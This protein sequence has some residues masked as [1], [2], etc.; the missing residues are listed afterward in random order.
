M[1]A[2]GKFG[3]GKLSVLSAIL[4][5]IEKIVEVQREVKLITH[6]FHVS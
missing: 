3:S 5:E 6:S 4:G 1:A 2:V